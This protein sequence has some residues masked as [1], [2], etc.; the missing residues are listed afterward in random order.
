M[1]IWLFK[2]IFIVGWFS[3]TLLHIFKPQILLKINPLN[4]IGH[5]TVKNWK[6]VPYT[7][8]DV[9]RNMKQFGIILFIVGVMASIFLI[10]KF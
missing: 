2:I 9:L 8:K 5:R 3:W 6:L 10:T 7:E 4:T 1:A